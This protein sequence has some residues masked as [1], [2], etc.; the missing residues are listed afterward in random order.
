[1]AE[2][3]EF[4]VSV[5]F[6]DL[7]GRQIWIFSLVITFAWDSFGKVDGCTQILRRG[8]KA[9]ENIMQIS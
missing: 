8:Q 6:Q 5:R 2:S 9:H 4:G 1:M 7:G 3:L